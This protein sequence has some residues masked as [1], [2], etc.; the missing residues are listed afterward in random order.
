M[1]SFL[2]NIILGAKVRKRLINTKEIFTFLEGGKFFRLICWLFPIF[3]EK[4]VT[5]VKQ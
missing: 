4:Y 1:I 3:G 5:E 2:G